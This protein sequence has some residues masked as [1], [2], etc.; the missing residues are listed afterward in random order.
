MKEWFG[1]M[2]FY[3]QTALD[4]SDPSLGWIRQD[5]E[6][7]VLA[8]L[9]Y[10][11]RDG[12]PSPPI[13]GRRC[14][15]PRAALAMPPM[16]TTASSTRPGSPTLWRATT[17]CARCVVISMAMTKP[18]LLLEF[19]SLPLLLVHDEKH[20]RLRPLA[21]LGLVQRD[22]W[23]AGTTATVE[24]LPPAW[25]E[26][27]RLAGGD[28]AD[29]TNRIKFAHYSWADE[30]GDGLIDA[31]ELR[32][33]EAHR[34]ANGPTQTNGGYCLR[35]DDGLN[36]W[37]GSGATEKF[38]MY[39]CSSRAY[40]RLRRASLAAQGHCR[41]DDGTHRRDQVSAAHRRRRHV[42]LAR[43]WW[44]WRETCQSQRSRRA[45]MG[46]PSKPDRRHGAP[47]ARRRWQTPVAKRQ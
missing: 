35:I 24:Q 32:L 42:R 36:A 7:V 46:W 34:D 9:D 5:D 22:L 25:A 33:G 23:A 1:G 38:G 27:I 4:P 3:T 11:K 18:E 44:R 6:T 37:V 19:T 28:P 16:M 20:D 40:H 10:A 8:K 31:K 30:N 21:C 12:S 43:R 26:A 39:G 47:A 13:A 41:S 14:L 2:D 17:A 15:I 45:W 29:A